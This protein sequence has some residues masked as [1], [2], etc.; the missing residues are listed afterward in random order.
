MRKEDGKAWQ[1]R[2]RDPEEDD[3]NTVSMV[4]ADEDDSGEAVV[5]LIDSFCLIIEEVVCR[6]IR[7]KAVIDTGAVVSVASPSLQEK[8]GAR[9]MGWDGPSVVMLNGQRAPPL[10]ALELEIEHRGMK[11]SRKVILLEMRGID[12]LLGN[13]F[14]SQFNRLQINYV[15]N[16]AELLLGELPVNVIEELEAVKA[17]TQITQ[18]SPRDVPNTSF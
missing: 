10:G 2:G 12:L 9:C 6:G 4:L 1:A 15:P 17:P 13:D 5:L 11:A 3:R 16:G 14:L 8:L 7:I 18:C